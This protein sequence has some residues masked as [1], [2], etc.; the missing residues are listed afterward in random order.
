MDNCE[1]LEFRLCDADGPT[2]VQ[3]SQHLASVP[4][5]DIHLGVRWVMGNLRREAATSVG[6]MLILRIIP[7]CRYLR[8]LTIRYE[9]NSVAL[10]QSVLAQ[11]INIPTC[12][13]Q[14]WL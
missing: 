14:V 12:V 7:S 4:Y 5:T 9:S 11:N 2:L 10:R 6:L 3:A 8:A 13:E 1:R